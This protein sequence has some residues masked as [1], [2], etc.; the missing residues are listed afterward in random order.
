[1]TPPTAPKPGKPARPPIPDSAGRADPY[2]GEVYFKAHYGPAGFPTRIVVLRA[3][4]RIRVTGLLM[5]QARAHVDPAMKT[6][7]HGDV[8]LLTIT[9][10][11]G[12]WVYVVAGYEPAADVYLCHWPD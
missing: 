11:N 6:T 12:T 2:A 8:E 4:P 10:S 5:R 1:M 9:A 7:V 3:D